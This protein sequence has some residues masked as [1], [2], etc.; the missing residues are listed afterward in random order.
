MGIRYTPKAV[1]VRDLRENLATYLAQAGSGQPV[2]VIQDGQSP[3]VL[4]READ[5]AEMYRTRRFLDDLESLIET[6]EIL[7]DEEMMD[8]IQ[9][10]MKD[11]ARNH[12]VTPEEAKAVLGIP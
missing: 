12:Y 5:L 9:R 2:S 4:I 3:V 8:K 10:S 7:A 6:Y 1:T 11:V